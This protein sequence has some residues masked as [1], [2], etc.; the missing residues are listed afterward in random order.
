MKIIATILVIVLLLCGG[1]LWFLAGGSLNEF[2][3]QQI[4]SQ[5][6][7]ITGQQV[8]V[9]QVDIQL[10]KGAGSIF[11]IVLANPKGYQNIPAFSLAEMTLD[12]N[13]TS[14]TNKGNEQPII[15]DAIII[16]Q[17]QAYVE[18]NQAGEA[19][20]QKILETIK[21][22]TSSKPKQQAPQ[23]TDNKEP[24][25]IVKKVILADTQL[26]LE[27]SAL[28]N[29]RHET[30]LSDIELTD[31]GGAKGVPASQLGAE[32]SKQVLSSIWKKAKKQQK[33]KLLKK[34]TEQFKD[35]A[36]K[37]LAELFN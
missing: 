25:I 34:A 5:G 23:S 2:V 36:K 19:N 3:K 21:A 6:Q 10:S 13:L 4:E 7:T 35:K 18:L 1:A 33:K 14:L 24:N 27:L 32:I 31:I 30:K 28:G 11:D 17:A 29:K 9:K 22:Q 8:T 12:I 20:Y 37:K 26:A 16:K 15:I